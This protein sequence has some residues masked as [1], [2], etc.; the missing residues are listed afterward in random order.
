MTDVPFDATAALD[1]LTGWWRDAGVDTVIDET[2]R[3]WLESAALATPSTRD[4][5]ARDTA[6][7][8]TAARDTAARDTAAETK[9]AA[10]MIPL[11]SKMPTTLA[12]FH[13]WWMADMDVLGEYPPRQRVAAAGRATPGLMVLTD[14]PELDDVREGALLGGAVGGYLDRMLAALKLDRSVVY[15]AALA[16]ARPPGGRLQAGAASDLLTEI[17]RHHIALAAPK[18]LWLLGQAASRAVIGVEP[19]A[20]SGQLHFVKY[21]DTMVPAIATTHPRVLLDRPQFKKAVWADMQR[22]M[23]DRPE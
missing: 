9:P 6:A 21:N 8:D 23:E 7:R 16:P 13:A 18:R 22:L 4:T 2:P 15:L 10:V 17:V 1:S 11:A 5:A 3:R 20:A 12:A 14:V 19:P